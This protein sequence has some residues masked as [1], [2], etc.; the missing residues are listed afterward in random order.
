MDT[1]PRTTILTSYYEG[2]H[3]KAPAAKD[4]GDWTFQPPAEYG[5]KPWQFPAVTYAAAVKEL[6]K[7]AVIGGVFSLLP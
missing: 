4:K 1:E 3:G 7:Q 6:T 2:V 5:R